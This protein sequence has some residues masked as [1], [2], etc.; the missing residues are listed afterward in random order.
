MVCSSSVKIILTSTLLQ[1]GL[2]NVISVPDGAPSVSRDDDDPP[3]TP[4]KDRKFSYLKSSQKLLQNLDY[5]C[6]VRRFF[7]FLVRPSGAV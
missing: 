1:I 2:W 7:F 3:P 5:A 4:E 6:D